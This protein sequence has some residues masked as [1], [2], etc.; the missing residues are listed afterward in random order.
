MA[1]FDVAQESDHVSPTV[2][3]LVTQTLRY[4]QKKAR[5]L[6]IYKG[7]IPVFHNT[8]QQLRKNEAAESACQPT[9]FMAEHLLQ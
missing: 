3:V 4:T 2:S 9:G 8:T 1:K 7:A 6:A 5:Q